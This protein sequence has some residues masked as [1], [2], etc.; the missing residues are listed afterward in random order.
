MEFLDCSVVSCFGKDNKYDFDGYVR[1]SLD[2]CFG[3][4][5]LT[6]PLEYII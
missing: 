5:L 2:N 4:F 3:Y 6:Y 1:N